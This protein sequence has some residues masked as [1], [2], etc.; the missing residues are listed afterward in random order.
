MK[1]CLLIILLCS[2]SLPA[3]APQSF[4]ISFSEQAQSVNTLKEQL[5]DSLKKT[6]HQV[7]ELSTKLA[8]LQLEV[9][10]LQKKLLAQGEKL[11]ENKGVYCKATKK[12]FIKAD[13][14]IT[15]L[16]EKLSG[17]QTSLASHENNAFTKTYNHITLFARE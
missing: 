3:D 12:D 10:N 5:G 17:V 2:L 14:E 7:T 1:K 15:D 8:E 4:V 9:A 16:S 11:L 6:V 13:R